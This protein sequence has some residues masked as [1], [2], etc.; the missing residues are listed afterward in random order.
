MHTEP[1]RPSDAHSLDSL[2][3]LHRWPHFGT[4]IVTVS[5][6]AWTGVQEKSLG[7]ESTHRTA[8]CLPAGVSIQRLLKQSVFWVQAQPGGPGHCGA[9]S[10]A[11]RS[12]PP[13]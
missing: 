12:G 5:A 1:T 10:S 8:H 13:A 9:M 11:G 7:H 4:H 6:P 2:H 3:G